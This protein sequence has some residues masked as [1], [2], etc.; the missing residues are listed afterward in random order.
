MIKLNIDQGS[1]AWFAAKC[2]RVTGT[3]FSALVAGESTATYKDLVSNIACEIITGRMEPSYTNAA[4]EHGIET[5]PYARKEYE[6]IF[7]VDVEEIGFVI[8]DDG[9]VYHEWIGV[10]PDGLTPDS[11][12]E[13]KCP[14]MKTHLGYISKGKLPS[15][16]RYQVQGQLFVTGYSHCD[17]MSYVEGMKPFIIRVE[18]DEE[19][20]AVF[21]ARL[22]KL[23]ADVKTE[24]ETYNKYQYD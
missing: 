8:P 15:E 2:G 22:D 6:S 17:F 1:E 3:R 23:I 9:H 20:F 21:E 14:M 10:S 24:L 4:M 13:I 7:G 5:E 12:L 18:R 19:L 11:L 16:Y